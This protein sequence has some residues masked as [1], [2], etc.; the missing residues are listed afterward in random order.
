MSSGS[1]QLR[2]VAAGSPK[3]LRERTSL[4]ETG[5]PIRGDRG[6]VGDLWPFR[7]ARELLVMRKPLNPSV[8]AN[9][10]LGE[11]FVRL[12]RGGM[13]PDGF[14]EQPACLL[15]IAAAVPER[16]GVQDER[17]AVIP[18]NATSA[19]GLVLAFSSF[20]LGLLAPL[21]VHDRRLVSQNVVAVNRSRQAWSTG[22]TSNPHTPERQPR[23][24]DTGAAN[25]RSPKGTDR[26]PS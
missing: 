4:L 10:Q 3:Q 18:F 26:S 20:L 6:H 16:V 25:R 12:L 15:D 23:T 21:P 14:F 17:L 9:M 11:A 22:S 13:N 8:I 1:L 24:H 7:R 19:N 2:R 5:K